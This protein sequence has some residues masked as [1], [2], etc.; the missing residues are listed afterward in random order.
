[1]CRQVANVLQDKWKKS[2]SGKMPWRLRVMRVA[3]S[4]SR[5]LVYWRLAHRL[6]WEEYE[7]EMRYWNKMISVTTMMDEKSQR[8]SFQDRKKTKSKD[9][10]L[11]PNHPRIQ[12]KKVSA[13]Q[14]WNSTFRGHS[15]KYDVNYRVFIVR[16]V[17]SCFLLLLQS[18]LNN[19][20]QEE[21]LWTVKK[22]FRFLFDKRSHIHQ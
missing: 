15:M 14:L 13:Q 21:R 20:I 1:M 19:K 22:S 4:T 16:S 2:N 7:I 3:G 17:F 8:L 12:Y 9:D 5:L 11:N 6:C 18:L 10:R